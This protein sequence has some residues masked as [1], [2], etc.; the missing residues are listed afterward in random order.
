MQNL[1]HAGVACAVVL[2][3][4]GVAVGV[5][6]VVRGVAAQP[7]AITEQAAG[8]QWDQRMRQWV[9]DPGTAVALQD[10][11]TEAAHQIGRAHV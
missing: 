2:P 6:Q 5:T 4:A 7:A 3:V 11:H 1:C 10:D 9:A 8:K